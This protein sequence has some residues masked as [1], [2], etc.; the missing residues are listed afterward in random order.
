MRYVRWKMAML[1]IQGV[2]LAGLY[3]W[4]AQHGS[5]I[6]DW[7]TGHT[8]VVVLVA[9]VG[10][11]LGLPNE[12]HARL[13]PLH[14]HILTPDMTAVFL[15]AVVGIL[16]FVVVRDSAARAHGIAAATLFAAG[17]LM[18]V[19]VAGPLAPSI[20]KRVRSEVQQ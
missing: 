9:G 20:R 13:R 19:A 7:S 3:S 2:L 16:A 17:Y 5:S 15:P 6:V 4:I 12:L 14:T 8:G 18:A 10:L 1:A 11:A